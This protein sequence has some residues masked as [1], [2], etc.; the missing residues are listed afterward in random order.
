MAGQPFEIRFENVA[1][2][3]ARDDKLFTPPAAP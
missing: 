1:V 3:A 2:S